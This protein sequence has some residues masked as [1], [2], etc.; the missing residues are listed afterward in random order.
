MEWVKFR[1]ARPVWVTTVFLVVGVAAM[2]LLTLLSREG[3]NP[4]MVAKAQSIVGAGGWEGLF[5][6][7]DTIVSVGGLLGFGVVIGWVFGREFS[8]G[9]IVGLCAS[10]VSRIAIA[11]AKLS[12]LLGWAVATTLALAASL[13]TVGTLFDVGALDVGVLRLVG[14]F[15]G[16]AVLT[17][18]LAVPCAWAATLGRGYLP[19]IGTIIGLVVLAQ[20]AVMSGA[21]G[22]FPFS[23]PGLWAISGGSGAGLVTGMQ[24]LL[25]LP[26]P[27]VFI[28]LT[29][30]AWQRLTLTP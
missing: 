1:R 7:A 6:A 29:L 23:A 12:I 9:T 28:A 5:A 26:V 2:G 13:L 22:W 17:A 4:V 8:D 10:P 21:G 15:L 11:A 20:M 24:L 19:A 30:I 16:I 18:L 3:S 27:V 25:V 14:K